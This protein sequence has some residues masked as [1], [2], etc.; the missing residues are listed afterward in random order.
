MSRDRLES[1]WTTPWFPI[2]EIRCLSTLLLASCEGV[3]RPAESTGSTSNASILASSKSWRFWDPFN[4]LSKWRIT[5]TAQ[6]LNF[7]NIR[8][9][10]HEIIDFFKLSNSNYFSTR[11]LQS[12]LLLPVLAA[13]GCNEILPKSEILSSS[14][15][16]Y[17]QQALG[18]CQK[19]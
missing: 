6:T 7:R 3:H 5:L 4:A 9:W 10:I 18:L 12:D 13:V 15:C 17:N 8:V 14:V 16:T 2:Q 19:E 11:N 1:G